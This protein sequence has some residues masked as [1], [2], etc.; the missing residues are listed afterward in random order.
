MPPADF[1]PELLSACTAACPDARFS[2][3]PGT[4]LCQFS[5]VVFRLECTFTFQIL[6]LLSAKIAQAT[7][8]QGILKWTTRTTR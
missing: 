2:H 8:Q 1:L 5:P 6:L 7:A 3:L 4:V